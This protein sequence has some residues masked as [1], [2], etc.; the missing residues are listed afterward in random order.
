MQQS[1]RANIKA[2]SIVRINSAT[3]VHK[4]RTGFLYHDLQLMEQTA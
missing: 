1:K 4:L 3:T 2:A